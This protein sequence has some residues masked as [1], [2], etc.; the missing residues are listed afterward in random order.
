MTI[1]F[2]S[3]THKADDRRVA[4]LEAASLA[5]AGFA[6]AQLCPEGG[7]PPPAV[8]TTTLR[9]RPGLLGRLAILPR[10]LA[11]AIRARPTAIHANEPDSWAVAL[12]AKAVTGSAVVFDAHEDYADPHRLARL[13]APL[14]RPAA[15][16]LR[17][18]FRVMARWTDGL[19]LATP[20]LAERFPAAADH[21]PRIVVRNLVPREEAE[22]MPRAASAAPGPLRL[23]ALGAMGRARGWPAALDAIARAA[24]RTIRLEVVGPFTDGSA[25]DFARAAARLGITGRVSATGGLPRSEALARAAEAHAALVLFAPGPANHDAA[26]PH[27]L[28]E[29]MALGLPVVVAATSR[30]AAALVRR[31]G[32]GLVVDS[33]DPDAIATALDAL[34]ADPE[35]RGRMG[36]A[37]RRALTA[38]YAWEEDAGRLAG[39][40]RRLARRAGGAPRGARAA[41]GSRHG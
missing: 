9:R 15:A 31:T 22:A 25:G 4:V 19:V 21:P 20:V 33:G 7:T 29:A 12:L 37:G 14:R 16:V 26:L 13:P 6:V 34:A 41:S 1:L 10:L 35:A 32:C 18:T 36:E 3:S 28:F 24:D 23:V 39:L 40:H 8:P 17:R 2:L 11:G 5:G 38:D 27:K 30:P